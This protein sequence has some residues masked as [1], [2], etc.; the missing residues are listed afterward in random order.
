MMKPF[1]FWIISFAAGMFITSC[2]QKQSEIKAVKEAEDSI[3]IA[4]SDSIIE[5]SNAKLITLKSITDQL[6]VY[7][8]QL[9]TKKI[10]SERYSSL[11]NPLKSRR[12]SLANYL[13]A[14]HI[15]ELNRY[16]DSVARQVTIRIMEF[17]KSHPKLFPQDLIPAIDNEPQTYREKIEEFVKK[18]DF[19]G[20]YKLMYGEPD[21]E[22]DYIDGHIRIKT[23]TWYCAAKK[24]RSVDFKYY[25]GIWY[26]QSEFTTNCID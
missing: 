21:S 18:K 12:D 10:T 4:R 2:V 17:K 9:E 7:Y 14:E 15:T 13:Q 25:D 26:K 16:N 5:L 20:M 24:Y 22:S 8:E 1:E 3:K 23:L 19:I 11:T 6:L